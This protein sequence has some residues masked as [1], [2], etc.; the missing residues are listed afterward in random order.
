MK[1]LGLKLLSIF[2]IVGVTG[3]DA[4]A[5]LQNSPIVHVERG[6]AETRYP[7]HLI[8]FADGRVGRVASKKESFLH[9]LDLAKKN[10]Q[11]LTVELSDEHTIQS[12]KL[13]TPSERVPTPTPPPVET[14][15]EP[16][17][18]DPKSA[19]QIF[20]EMNPH[21]RTRAQCYNK[22]HVWAFEASAKHQLN[23]MK[24]FMFFTAKYIREYRYQWWFHVSP[25][26]YVKTDHEVSER[27][28]DYYFMKEPVS[29]R[30]WSDHFIA[31]K[32]EFPTVTHYSDYDQHQNDSYC[33]FMKVP[34]FYWQ[35]Q[36]LEKL[37]QDQTER[38]SFVPDEI[39]FA[40]WQG[41]Y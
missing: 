15:Y 20:S 11:E 9:D 41:F 12:W 5:Y 30:T 19:D 23:S 38:L 40:Y 3:N 29:M 1:N 26:T 37:E 31:P 17:I 2:V 16:S 35:P 34:M 27:V 24:V 32:T 22:A 8:Y 21:F 36:D 7:E 10:G 39:S 13:K 25:F 18:I 33:Y 28:L 14:V 6:D 4:R